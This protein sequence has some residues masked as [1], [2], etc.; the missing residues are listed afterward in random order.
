MVNILAV[1]TCVNDVSE[2]S[3][4]D[5]R[6][7]NK[8]ILRLTDDSETS[9]D[10]VLW[11]TQAM[12]F[13]AEK[14]GVSTIVYIKYARINVFQGALSITCSESST[15]ELH[16]STGPLSGKSAFCSDARYVRLSQWWAQERGAYI[17]ADGVMIVSGEL[18][19]SKKMTWA[20]VTSS[21][22]GFQGTKP[23]FCLQGEI[24]DIFL[25]EGSTQYFLGCPLRSCRK[26][27][28][29]LATDSSSVVPVS[30][31]KGALIMRC[32]HCKENV[33]AL[34]SYCV[35]MSVTDGVGAERVTVFSQ[36]AQEIFGEPADYARRLRENND[37]EAYRAFF[38]AAKG[39]KFIFK[40]R[41][42]VS[43][44]NNKTV[45]QF[46]VTQAQSL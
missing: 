35:T 2:F 34:I 39:K 36:V 19:A 13:T 14:V 16:P 23:S 29:P 38:R 6:P 18:A 32:T 12:G 9:C 5:G 41:V 25:S 11:N 37:M 8:R 44:Y 42:Q 1:V 21:V 20:E 45:R 10:M 22:L 7:V 30:D 3:T 26:K 15:V 33:A 17:N 24:V 40:I 27:L 43:S 4:K 46:H 28:V 31:N